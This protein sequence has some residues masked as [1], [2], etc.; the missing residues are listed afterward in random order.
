MIFDLLAIYIE[1][2]EGSFARGLIVY[3]Y[4][5]LF[6]RLKVIPA[7]LYLGIEFRKFFPILYY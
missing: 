4:R 7:R 6:H 5:E 2:A 1:S 3:F